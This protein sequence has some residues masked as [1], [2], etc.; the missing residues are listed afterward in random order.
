MP[1]I[2]TVDLAEARQRLKRAGGYE[3]RAPLRQAIAKMSETRMLELEPDEGE[4]LRSLK[5]NVARAA[6][7][8]NREVDS[9]VSA[10]GTL[11]VWLPDKPKRKRGPRKRKEMG[12]E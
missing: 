2:R 1:E 3:T 6:K 12:E 11:L 5:L 4:S 7:E 9:G 10:E 8:V